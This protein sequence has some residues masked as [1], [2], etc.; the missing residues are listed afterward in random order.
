MP[1]HQIHPNNINHPQR[2]CLKTPASH[3][4]HHRGSNETQG[5]ERRRGGVTWA[6]YSLGRTQTY[7]QKRYIDID[8]TIHSMQQVVHKKTAHGIVFKIR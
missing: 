7:V 5:E 2:I 1:A 8:V 6:N 4:S 3:K